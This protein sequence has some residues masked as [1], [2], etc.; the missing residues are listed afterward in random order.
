[1]K[2]A[3]V[4]VFLIFSFF[5]IGALSI[6]P[7]SW[8]LGSIT[9]NSGIQSLDIRIYNDTK[10]KIKID[11]ISTC[12]CLSSSTDSLTLQ[13]DESD[14]IQFYF[15]PKDERG[16]VSKFMIIRTSQPDL[17]KALFEIKGEVK[18]AA[19]STGEKGFIPDNQNST[20][21]DAISLE[22]EEIPKKAINH[23]GNTVPVMYY[24]SSGCKSCIRFLNKRIPALE[25]ELGIEI[26]VETRDIMNPQNY[27]E[28]LSILTDKEIESAEFPS[29]LVG[30]RLLQGSKSINSELK[31]ALR[32]FLKGTRTV[33][34]T[35]GRNHLSL[36]LVPIVLAGLLDG[37]NPCVFSTLLFLIS[38]LTLIG[39][40]RKE[41]LVIGIF[42][43]LAVFVTYY[44]VG[45]GLFQGIRSASVFPF[46][47]DII[48]W[49]LIAVLLVISLLSFRDFLL[50]RK[51]KAG[52]IY[53]QLP[54]LLKLKIHGV[55][56][57]NVRRSSLITGSLVLGVMVS[58][59]ELAC[60]GQ[61]Y[62]PTIAYMIQSGRSSAY[63]Y[64]LIYNFSFIIPLF[65]VFILIYEGTGSKGITVFFQKSMGGIKFS[66]AVLFLLLAV[67]VV[68]T[69]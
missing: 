42:F 61:V 57:G 48:K 25:K 23:S 37:I 2:Q 54:K 20:K 40:S 7:S 9:S 60:T 55:I 24:Y 27:E 5:R 32:S 33:K 51:G 3:F 26:R 41:I 39:R 53:L 45:M 13:P 29:L 4:S 35:E 8:D 62:F 16:I 43:S 59:F 50:I 46:A 67:I 36:S 58:V 31:D 14:D 22:T 10:E 34:D 69:Q 47:A 28:Y 15:N 11:F 1:M 68:F 56:R 52:E 19:D 18:E 38:A 64:L 12:D 6:T 17:P 49:V 21:P 66:L 63:F 30:T 44:L 65:V